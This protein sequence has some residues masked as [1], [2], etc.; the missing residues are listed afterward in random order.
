MKVLSNKN[1]WS[2]S[3]KQRVEGQEFIH[4][5]ILLKKNKNELTDI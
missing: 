5:S 4:V 2:V 1:S 3:E